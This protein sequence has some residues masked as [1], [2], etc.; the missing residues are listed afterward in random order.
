MRS[1]LDTL[2]ADLNT[3]YSVR[4]RNIVNAALAWSRAARRIDTTPHI[5]ALRRAISE[6]EAIY[7]KPRKP[8]RTKKGTR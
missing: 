4:A 2:E 3:V 8:K 5:R 7:G 1:G 6:Y